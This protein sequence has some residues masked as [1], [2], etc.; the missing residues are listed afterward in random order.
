MTLVFVPE[1]ERAKVFATTKGDDSF[2]KYVRYSNY[3]D[4]ITQYKG[5]DPGVPA[6]AYETY[7]YCFIRLEDDG[8]HVVSNGVNWS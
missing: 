7:R 1:N 6:G 2:G 5:S 4:C 8:W 3:S